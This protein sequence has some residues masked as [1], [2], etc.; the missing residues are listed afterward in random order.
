VF[1]VNV[2][3]SP[4]D[5]KRQNAEIQQYVGADQ[6]EGGK[7]MGE[8][9]LKDLGASAKITYG[10]VGDPE[11]IP[12]NQR[13]SGFKAALKANPNAH[14]VGVVNS[15]VD[16]QVSLTVATDMLQGNPAMNVV[17]ADTGPGAVGAI[18][19]IKQL[20]RQG[21]TA[22]YGFCAA[23][24]ALDSTLYRGCAAQEPAD[25]ARTVVENVA[26]Y[27][28]QGVSVPKEIL[29]PLKIFGEGA[30]PAAGEVG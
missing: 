22:L 28:K 15:K 16:P 17:F 4:G 3:V 26:K 23:D 25:Y 21:T 11:Q 19:A 18:Q 10:I 2:I 1:T 24:T 14:F 9:A 5:L 6:V 7:M 20:K 30:K 12:T 13:D 27:V 8:A 29:R